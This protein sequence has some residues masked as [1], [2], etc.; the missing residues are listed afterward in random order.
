[1]HKINLFLLLAISVMICCGTNRNN[2][3]TETVKIL[4][5]NVRNA[6]G[7]DEVTDYNRVA[8]VI[9]RIDADCA[10][11]QEL[12][13]ATQRS[14][15][16]IVLDELAKRTGMFATYNKSIDYQGGGYGIGILTKEKPLRKEAVL[17]PG[18]EEQ[19][20][21]LLVEMPDY[22][23]CCTHW[24]L[25]QP[26][27]M[28]SVDVINEVIKNYTSKP[29]FLAGDLNAVPGSEE[30]QE[31]SKAW[32][33]LNDTLQPTIP[34]SNP[35]KCIDYVMVKNNPKF[36]FNVLETKVENE[37]MASDHLP[38]WVTVSVKNNN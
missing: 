28:A 13:S 2:N 25:N 27:R 7:M 36:V 21:L 4:S 33:F 35:E 23:I 31:L 37:T 22:V 30:I 11:I 15:G 29:I 1:M 18:S 6:R 12:D 32:S 17:L 9:K 24:S 34:A 38:I 10:A 16:F 26:D 14:G 8:S 19:R 3:K 20:S 5:Y